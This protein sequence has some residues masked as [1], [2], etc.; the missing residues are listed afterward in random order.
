VIKLLYQRVRREIRTYRLALDDPRT[1][2]SAKRLLRFTLVY[3]LSP[4]DL[5]PDA[6]PIL[7]LIDDVI[8]IPGLLLTV[9]WL[10]PRAVW[11]DCRQRAAAS[12]P[13]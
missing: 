6:I 7:G 3:L 12:M 8:L 1:P 4:L 5:I 11:T 13:H 10:I 2:K 9:R